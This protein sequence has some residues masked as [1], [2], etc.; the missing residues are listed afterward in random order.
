MTLIPFGRYVRLH[1]LHRVETAA[2][3]LVVRMRVETLR[4]SLL[5]LGEQPVDAAYADDPH[6]GAH[7][8]REV[9]LPRL[10]AL[11]DADDPWGVL[12]GLPA[13]DT[14]WAQYAAERGLPP[15][16]R[17]VS[18]IT[19]PPVRRVRA[20]TTLGTRLAQAQRALELLRTGIETA[21]ALATLWQNWQIGR[22]QVRLLDAQRAALHGV[23]EGQ[24]VAQ[25]DALARGVEPDYVRRYLADHSD[26]AAYRAVFDE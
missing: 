6:A 24:L 8:V 16:P 22:A 9:M 2:E 11:L 23:I 25:A 15:A 19:V 10:A 7:I 1:M 3:V 5:P 17:S 18:S 12:E 4:Y 14:S 20:R 13:R 26:D 21:S